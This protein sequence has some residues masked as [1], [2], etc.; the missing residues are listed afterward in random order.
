MLAE[1]LAT[2]SSPTPARIVACRETE[3]WLLLTLAAGFLSYAI[4]FPRY[5]EATFDAFALT[6][7]ASA[8]LALVAMTLTPAMAAR[9]GNL[10][11]SLHTRVLVI[12]LLALLFFYA[13]AVRPTLEPFASI[14]E[15]F[16]LYGLRDF[17]E[18]SLRNLAAYLSWPVVVA[19]GFGVIW[20]I[21]RRWGSR[22]GLLRPL[23]LV[24]A[25][26]PALLYLWTP[27][28]SPDHPWAFRRFI[29]LV[30]PSALL[31]AATLVNASTR[32]AGQIGPIVGGLAL[33]CLPAV[34]LMQQYPR[35]VLFIR[36]ND[37]LTKQIAAIATQ[38]PE[39][40]IVAD[41]VQQDIGSVLFVAFDR[42]VAVADGGLDPYGDPT[43]ITDWI[44]AKAASGHPAWLLHAPETWHTGA[45]WSDQQAWWVTREVIAPS[46]KPPATTIERRT[47]EIILSRV[48]GLDRTFASRMFGAERIWGAAEH[49]FFGT[50]VATFGMFRYTNGDAWLEVPA[51]PLRAADALKVDVF[52]FAKEGVHRWLRVRIDAQTAWEGTVGAGLAT[53]RMAMPQLAAG[54]VARIEIQSERADPA[55]MGAR[56]PRMSLSVGLV[57]IRPFRRSAVAVPF[58]SQNFCSALEAIAVGPGSI[59]IS[60][61]G[62]GDFVADVRNCGS[63]YW[64]SGRDWGA[65]DSGMVQIAL[66]WHERAKPNNIVADNRWPLLLS[67]LP[68]D[69]TRIRIPLRP[70]GADGQTL[71]LGDYD[72]DVKMVH[73]PGGASSQGPQATLSVPVAVVP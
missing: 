64:Q 38:L 6:G 26:G 12:F 68:G 59:R 28:V 73:E 25:L 71:P 39:G 22:R 32:R 54:D 72:I 70:I 36:E 37:G 40:L 48:D 3:W 44:K 31:F 21:W 46:V 20:A 58:E 4:L 24:L 55:D 15:S 10:V 30:V 66:R 14:Q 5:F 19:A 49:G 63:A 43:A 61:G 41:G 56:D 23:L 60:K 17:R 33:L 13:A 34:L 50:E 7:A 45:Y 62:N 1:L 18:D 57:G 51:A 9:T 8:G 65:V 67:L 16:S 11:S 47:S 35:G 2:C 27:H 53:V 69:R 29:P 52:T 42:P